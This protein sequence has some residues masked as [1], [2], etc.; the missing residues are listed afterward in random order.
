MDAYKL[1]ILLVILFIFF[2]A[3]CHLKGL[4]KKGKWQGYS[5]KGQFYTGVA[6]SLFLMSFYIE[7]FTGN[8]FLSLV[9]VLSYVFVLFYALKI[10]KA[11]SLI[12]LKT[13]SI[14]DNGNFK[15]DIVFSFYV[16]FT[17]AMCEAF[18]SYFY[19]GLY[20]WFYPIGAL[21]LVLLIRVASR[22]TSS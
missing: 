16:A 7:D 13:L 12:H 3:F 19:G 2:N 15:S 22:N 6:F 21:S 9:F 5:A 8:N 1:F 18:Q 14:N 4:A 20:N 17:I 10:E 11:A